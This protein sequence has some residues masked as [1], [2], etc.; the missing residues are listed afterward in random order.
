MF[1]I[2][3]NF[4]MVE[5]IFFSSQVKRNLII[6]NKLVHIPPFKKK[7]IA[8]S[9]KILLKIRSFIFPPER[10]LTRKLE[11]AS[12]I[13]WMIIVLSP[14]KLLRTSLD[15]CF[16][17]PWKYLSL[18]KSSL[19]NLTD[20]CVSWYNPRLT[21]WF[22]RLSS[23]V[24]KTNFECWPLLQACRFDCWG[25]R[26]ILWTTRKVVLPI[27]KLFHSKR[28]NTSKKWQNLNKNHQNENKELWFWTKT[29][30]SKLIFTFK[31]WNCKSADK[32]PRELSTYVKRS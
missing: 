27:C 18:K 25:V 14:T 19:D 30:E 6:S 7:N 12:N 24:H 13:L 4:L 20:S 17:P 11:F 15:G 22:M 2:F 1:I 29:I 26:I 10:Y 16:W 31:G 5:Q 21:Y 9:G 23:L 3:W 8:S 32:L 28:V